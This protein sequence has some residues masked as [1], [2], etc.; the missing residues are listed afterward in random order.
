MFLC[1]R[2]LLSSLKL[3][4][5]H[6][7]QL[8]RSK[9]ECSINKNKNNSSHMA[10][11]SFVSPPSSKDSPDAIKYVEYNGREP[12]ECKYI[13]NKNP[14]IMKC[15][16]S[17]SEDNIL[18]KLMIVKFKD[19]SEEQVKEILLEKGI[20]CQ[21]CR[22]YF[23]GHSDEQLKNKICY[24]MCATEEDIQALLAQLT[25]FS[26]RM[27]VADRASRIGA[28]FSDYRFC[29][30]LEEKEI[31]FIDNPNHTESTGMCGFMSPQLSKQVQGLG[32]LAHPPS[33][34]QIFHQSC[35][36][37]LLRSEEM[38]EP[39]KVQLYE[40]TKQLPSYP[41]PLLRHA[42]GILD[43]ARPYSNGYLD[44]QTALLLADKGVSHSNMEALQ[45]TYYD[46]LDK[47][48]DETH[49]LFFLSMTGNE[50]LRAK[51]QE[52]GMTEEIKAQ[53]TA[54][55]EEEIGKMLEGSGQNTLRV[56]VPQAREVAG[57]PDPYSQLKSGEC[58]FDPT[59]PDGCPEKAEFKSA[60]KVL[61]MPRP[62]YNPEDV[63]VLK[64]AKNKSG[65][66]NLQDCL[67][68]PNEPEQYRTKN[69][70][71]QSKRTYFVTWKTHLIPSQGWNFRQDI[72]TW[73]NKLPQI[74]ACRKPSPVGG[75][76][77]RSLSFSSKRLDSPKDAAEEIRRGRQDLVEYFASFKDF[78]DLLYH[79]K[80]IYRRFAFLKGPSCKE[81]YQLDAVLSG[82]MDLN[83]D[84]KKAE[85]IIGQ[86]EGSYKRDE[87]GKDSDEMEEEDGSKV[88]HNK[89]AS[90]VVGRMEEIA[91]EYVAKCRQNL[92]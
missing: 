85:K 36:G 5:S 18:E 45:K 56:L 75:P 19:T 1:L 28:L 78:D 10:Y 34:I 11:P 90:H 76:R 55:K 92:R 79:A 60:E 31:E 38:R 2:K 22:Y 32:D 91:R 82:K 65:Y 69:L 40:S 51:L 53:L 50:R 20:E 35:Q 6:E 9:L 24:V 61:V 42:L 27:P 83:T 26:Q 67:V 57:V 77:R 71:N 13:K 47:L 86:L 46:I 52:T 41:H 33:V 49:A 43:I 73:W 12:G 4:K 48:G 7:E 68:L 25:D 58:F 64:L 37:L 81:C 44:T 62:C 80:E 72:R 66:E 87:T 8:E 39:V 88:F 15:L 89:E 29:L 84:K 17:G 3:S 54:I 30:E 14:F 59:L 74:A 23:L 21:G 16:A 63:R 70:W